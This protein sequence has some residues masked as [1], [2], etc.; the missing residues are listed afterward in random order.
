VKDP[1]LTYE[2]LDIMNF[3]LRYIQNHP[4]LRRLTRFLSVGALATFI[5]LA[6]FSLLHFSLGFSAIAANTISYG[7]GSINSF[8]MHRGWTYALGVQ[9][10][11]FVVVGLGALLINDLVI[12][13]AP[14]VTLINTI[15][16]SGSLAAKACATGAGM[17]WN[18][19]INHFWTFRAPYPT[20]IPR[21]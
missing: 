20:L 7:A 21:V 5:D 17:V 10:V 3:L 18:F 15:P 6:L 1:E 16:D 13:L 4:G 12:Y 19:M 8:S 2:V 14:H 11:Q 9:L